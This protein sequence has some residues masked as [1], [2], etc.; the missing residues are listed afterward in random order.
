MKNILIV[1]GFLFVHSTNSLFAQS[2]ESQLKI[3]FGDILQENKHKAARVIG[4]ALSTSGNM[5]YN[6]ELIK[7]QNT[8]EV[9]INLPPN[10]YIGPD[11]KIYPNQ[12][13]QW[14]NP[15]KT[16]DYSV[17]ILSL[18][19][20]P[21][22]PPYDM[23]LIESDWVKKN[24]TTLNFIFTYNWYS[25]FNNDQHAELSE[26]N[27]IKRS[28]YLGE[29]IEFLFGFTSIS[30]NPATGMG[31]RSAKLH[32]IVQ[33][34]N[35]ATGELIVKQE[36]DETIPGDKMLMKQMTLGNYLPSGKYLVVVSMS[37]EKKLK[38]KAKNLLKEYFEV[39][40]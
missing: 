24:I 10:T 25:D 18:S 1:L 21:S 17:D 37:S 38:P 26:F 28:F 31:W 27:N 35:A 16:D 34:F 3:I 22:L 14:T 2:L 4:R 40:E 36:F 8:R 6:M 5:N 39:I 32:F 29:T 30:S 19:R 12:G 13:F 9:T 11:N 23:S 15:T 33:L 7:A 20:R